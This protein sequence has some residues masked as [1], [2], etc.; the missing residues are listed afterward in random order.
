QFLDLGQQPRGDYSEATA[1]AIDSEVKEI[2][3]AQYK[4]AL[5]ILGA[6]KDVLAEGA[7]ILLEKEKIDGEEIRALLQA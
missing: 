1:E 3:S 5:D 7:R 6:R 2:I 4:V